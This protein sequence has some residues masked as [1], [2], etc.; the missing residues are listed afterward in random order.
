M[1][2]F[3]ASSVQ[4]Y[5]GDRPNVRAR[6]VLAT[7]W[8]LKN[9]PLLWWEALAVLGLSLALARLLPSRLGRAAG[10]ARYD[11]TR[12][13]RWAFHLPHPVAWC[14]GRCGALRRGRRPEHDLQ[15][16][17]SP[18]ALHWTQS[19]TLLVM[20]ILGG[21]GTVGRRAGAT[22]LLLLEELLAAYTTYWAFW[23]GWVLLA[24]VLFARR[25]IA[26]LL[27]R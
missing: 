20:V 4:A 23:T 27:V 26:G 16:Y 19:G 25:G 10:A 21:T 3:L 7:G 12:A 24:V 13:G 17:V 15:G 9:G 8:D 1:L 18:N 2:Y 11:E 5:G 14:H 6:S 22:A